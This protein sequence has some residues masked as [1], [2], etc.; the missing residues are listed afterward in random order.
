MIASTVRFPPTDA[1]SPTVKLFE[2]PIPPTV[3]IAPVPT[4]V[5][6]VVLSTIIFPELASAPV[7]LI[8][9]DTSN[10]SVGAVVLIPTFCVESTLIT[11]RLT[12]LSFTFISMFDPAV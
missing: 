3:V 8:F 6:S 9:P 7:V 2:I 4:L 12:P 11:V 10:A 5:E 1:F